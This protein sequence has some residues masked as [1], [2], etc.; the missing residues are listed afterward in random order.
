[1]IEHDARPVAATSIGA[2]SP[3]MGSRA[4]FDMSQATAG[5]IDFDHATA[6][7][8]R[9]LQLMAQH[10]V[11]AT[12]Q[13]FE[14]W[15][16]FALG[17]SP[18]LNKII[19]ILIENKRSFD[20]ATN[21]S[22]FQAYVEVDSDHDAGRADVSDQLHVLLST[23]R[24][25]LA[26]SLADNRKHV[27]ALGGVAAEIQQNADPRAIV[28]RLVGEL[29]KAVARGHALEANF[30]ASLME[31]DKVRSHLA[32]AEHRSR[33]DVLTGL[34]NRLALD[35]FLRA[36]QMATMESGEALSIILLDIDHFKA[37]ND[38]FGHQFGDQILRLIAQLLQ[39]GLRNDDHAARFGGEELV[40]VLPGADV[41]FA[42][43]VAERI[44]QAIANHQITRRATGEVLTGVTVSIGV[45][46]FVPGE[47]LAR[48]FERCDR[49]LYAAKRGG[50][51]RTITELE[52]E[53]DVAAA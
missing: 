13:N 25:Y 19:N 4:P 11:P 12:P 48:L 46:Q 26:T 22:L 21:R 28:E 33:T 6:T 30:N 38:R 43:G 42:K 27:A 49:A 50:R 18:E 36:A 29:S 52:V 14:V 44:R 53:R 5:D 45:A 2:A 34:A 51:N 41:G 23:A 8:G 15:Y 40:G 24:E 31:L 7:A 20:P 32:A 39:H 37:F 17:T 3:I 1:V 16:K 9:A 10:G 35:D 47:T